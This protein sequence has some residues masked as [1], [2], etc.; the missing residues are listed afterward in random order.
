MAF[1]PGGQVFD[2][3]S[4]R[5]EVH[6]EVQRFFVC[7]AHRVAMEL[8]EYL[9]TDPCDPLV[10]VNER[11]V[12]G[13]RLHERSSFERYR[14]IGVHSKRR[15][16]RTSN[17]RSEAVGRAHGWSSDRLGIERDN[18]FNGWKLHLRVGESL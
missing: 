4:V 1:D 7:R 8:K 17:G 16:L 12:F 10:A 15:L 9:S 3:H 11:L 13:Q 14:R 18:V 5:D 6:K 2:G